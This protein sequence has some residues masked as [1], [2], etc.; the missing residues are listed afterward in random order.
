VFLSVEFFRVSVNAIASSRFKQL[1]HRLPVE[2][3]EKDVLTSELKG[4]RTL[5]TVVFTDCVGFSARMSVDEDHTLDLIR[6]DLKLM[7]HLCEEYEGRVLKSTGDGLLMCFTSAVK[8]VEYAVEVQKKLIGKAS[9]LSPGDALKHRIGIHLADIFINETDV[10]GNGVNIAARLQTL[11]DPSGICISQTVYDVVKAGLQ[12]GTRYLGP[13]ELKNIREVV[14]VYKI[15]LSPELE[16]TELYVDVVHNLEQN[17]NIARIKKLL[18]YSCKSTWESSQSVVDSFPL[19]AL[20]HELLEVAPTPNRLKSFL[21]SAVKTLSKPAEYSLVANDIMNEVSRLY[22]GAQKQLA[23]ANSESAFPFNEA[24]VATQAELN[25]IKPIYQQ[26]AL[27]LEQTGNLLRIKK[28]IFYVCKKRWESDQNR[29][30]ETYL[31]GLVAELHQLAP[32]LDRLNVLVNEFVQTLSKQAE[33]TL[34]ANVL[35]GKFQKLYVDNEVVGTQANPAIA[36]TPSNSLLPPAELDAQASSSPPSQPGEQ[37]NYS[38]IAQGLKQDPKLL[39]IK[40]LMLYVSRRQWETDAAK[41]DALNLEPLIQELHQQH[42]TQTQL[43]LALNS[44]VKLLNKQ[45]EYAAIARSI[46]NQLNTLYASPAAPVQEA[47]LASISEKTILEKTTPE[48]TIPEKTASN[49]ASPG[50]SNLGRS[51][52]GSKQPETVQQKALLSLFDYRLGVIKYANPLRAKLLIFSAL[53]QDFSE[54]DQDWF[55]LKAYDLDG[56]I[57]RLLSTCKTYTDMEALLYS[58]A[59]RFRETEENLN[60]ATTVIKCLRPFYLH[61]G[62]VLLFN[63]STEDTQISLD[64]F[65]ETTLEFASASDE[66]DFTCQLMTSVSSSTGVLEPPDSSSSDTRLLSNS[67]QDKT[68]VEQTQLLSNPNQAEKSNEDGSLQN[69]THL[70]PP[71]NQGAVG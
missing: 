10:M 19:E 26:I 67:K 39:R 15:L 3:M 37:I 21:D 49:P 58:A 14:P 24:T 27:E 29:L 69:Q 38:D 60:T 71:S 66:D 46:L 33:Y 44:V 59:R 34:V 65:E 63:E 36:P 61:G 28:L 31:P 23:H 11:A 70:H 9:S 51:S 56:L 47:V 22:D 5:A 50:W 48:K 25:P 55:N 52:S 18:F 20:L 40:K 1:E 57:R 64:D 30:N 8:A 32:T 12:V 41:L 13:R 68:Q 16:L 35:L 45:E 62:S 6:R 2:I 17:K 7:K 42:Q 54:G 4:Q 53:H 43:E